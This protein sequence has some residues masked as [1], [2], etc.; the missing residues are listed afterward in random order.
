M[1][2][3]YALLMSYITKVFVVKDYEHAG[4]KS[5]VT[6]MSYLAE[7]WDGFYEKDSDTI[8]VIFIGSSI[9]HTD[10]DVNQM[11]HDYGFTSYN[12]SADQ[13]SGSS[14]LFFLKEALKYQTPQVVFI[15]VQAMSHPYVGT[16]TSGHYSFDFMKAGINKVQGIIN[17]HDSTIEDLLFPFTKYHARWEELEQSDFDYVFSDKTNILN[18]HMC[19]TMQNVAEVPIEYEPSSYTLSELGYGDTEQCLDHV[20]E[21]C[22][23]AGVECVLLRTPQSYTYAQ[24]KYCDALKLYAEEKG[25]LFWNCNEY[26]NEIGIDFSTDFVDGQHM[27]QMGSTKFSKFLGQKIT[28]SFDLEDHKGMVGYEEWDK[29]YDYQNHLIHNYEMKNYTSAQEYV[30]N[31]DYNSEDLIFIYTYDSIDDLKN[32]SGIPSSINDITSSGNTSNICILRQGEVVENVNLYSGERWMGIDDYVTGGLEIEIVD[33]DTKLWFND[34]YYITE[35]AQTFVDLLIYDMMLGRPVDHVK[36][37]VG[38]ASN[39]TRLYN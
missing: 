23:Q 20:V 30:D 35:D 5:D 16:E 8:D 25:V 12:L 38:L 34:N 3:V 19:N 10:V 9:I 33:G 26:Y 22:N 36:I 32:V 28:E 1:V 37:N 13:Q 7:K 18:G 11:Y 15:D 31:G 39:L 29:S 2:L 4:I 21:Y 14:I 17:L 27:N 6:G 24:S